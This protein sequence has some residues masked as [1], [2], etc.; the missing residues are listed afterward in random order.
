VTVNGAPVEGNDQSTRLPVL[1]YQSDVLV[2]SATTSRGMRQSSSRVR[3]ATNT[4]PFNQRPTD[5]IPQRT[6]HSMRM[7]A[8]RKFSGQQCK[9]RVGDKVLITTITIAK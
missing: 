8:L 1:A 2:W 3:A 7:S 6:W 9:L 5:P 4:T